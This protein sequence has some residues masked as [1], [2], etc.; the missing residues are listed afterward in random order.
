MLYLR[1]RGI[2]LEATR[3]LLIDAFVHEMV[4]RIELEPLRARL[5][6]LVAGRFGHGDRAV[7]P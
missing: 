2:P 3:G 4:D 6:A 5:K 7:E 1:A